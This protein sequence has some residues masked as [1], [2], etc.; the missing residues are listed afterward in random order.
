MSERKA[1]QTGR[2]LPA[3]LAV[4]VGLGAIALVTLLLLKVAFLVFVA[5][6]VAVALWELSHVLATRQIRL[7]LVP[8][9]AGGAAIYALAYWRGPHW[10]VGALGLSFIAVLAWRLPGGAAGYLRDVTAGIFALI[11][12]TFMAS[13]V[14][15][16]LRQHDGSHRVLVFLILA[17]CSDTGAYFAGILFGRHLM[18]PRISPK[19]TWEGLAGSVIACLA[20]GALGMYYLLDSKVWYGLVLGAAAAA[21]A[22]LGDL[23]ESQIKRDL[24]TKD[25]GS[26]LPG[27]GGVLD[28]I[29]AMLIVAPVAWLL[30]TIFLRGR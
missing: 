18:A 19:K 6:M 5:A 24:D 10:A 11:Y 15:L 25:M 28:R 30:M 13:F 9:G 29:D 2:N 17:V 22:T 27:H 26:I 16:M 12:L 7:S 14:A 21:A 20:A 8:L 4:G 1:I 3:A 23:V